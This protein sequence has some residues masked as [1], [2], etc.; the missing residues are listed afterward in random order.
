MTVDLTTTRAKDR[1]VTANNNRKGTK[2]P[3]FARASQNMATVAMLLDTLLTPSSNEVEKV[4]HQ[5]KDILGIFTMK[6]A[7]SSL[8]RPLRSRARAALRLAGRRLPWN[9][10]VAGMASS[11]ARILAHVWLSH[12]GRLPKPQARHQAHRGDENA[13]SEHYVWNM[14]RGGHDDQEGHS[15]SLEGLGPMAFGSNMCGT[16]FPNHFQALNNV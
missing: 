4:Y 11:V 16:R 8:Q 3:A 13:Q 2:R 7:E 15:L 14:H 1:D 12:T 10:P 5:L 6:Q 9:H